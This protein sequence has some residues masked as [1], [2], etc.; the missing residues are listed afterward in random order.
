MIKTAQSLK[1]KSRNIAKEKN[2]TVQEVIQN[3][4]FE[5]IIERLSKSKYKNNFILKGGFL[6]SSIIGI[7]TRT[8]MDIDTSLKGLELNDKKIYNILKEIL[9]IDLGDNVEFQILNS[10]PIREEDA[11]GGFKYKI[12]AKLDNLRVN[13]SIDIAT[14]DKI[15]PR[16]IEYKYKLMFENR[17]VQIMSYNIET[18]I[19]EKLETII[20]RG[21]LN[22][23]MKDYYDLYYLFKYKKEDISSKTLERAI[24]N[25]FSKRNTSKENMDKILNEMKENRFLNDLWNSYKKRYDYA[26]NIKFNEII[27]IILKEI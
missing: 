20:S 10:K 27:D 3:Y 4:M 15:T 11:Y 13:L 2:I 22:S 17:T 7:D 19:A 18:I 1:D 16:E 8:T 6:L 25:T 14:G 23:R 26:K 5:R 24:E 21:V 12:L 9:S